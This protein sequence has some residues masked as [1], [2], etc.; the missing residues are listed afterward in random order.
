MGRQARWWFDPA[1]SALALYDDPKVKIDLR[2][3]VVVLGS[4]APE[5]STWLWA[6][7]IKPLARSASRLRTG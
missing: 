6:L 3:Q 2:A 4:F 7:P 1:S 5:E